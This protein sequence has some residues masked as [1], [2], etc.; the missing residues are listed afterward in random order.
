V[1][2]TVPAVASIGS[3]APS[4]APSELTSAPRGMIY[5]GSR[6]AYHVAGDGREGHDIFRDSDN[7]FWDNS[8]TYYG[9]SNGYWIARDVGSHG[10]GTE[11][12]EGTK[13]SGCFY[14]VSIRRCHTV[15]GPQGRLQFGLGLPL[16]SL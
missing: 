1:E 2:V 13:A 9:M 8:L 7:R 6:G 14:R 3:V 12:R 11:A 5:I 15:R 10:T 16:T 4:P